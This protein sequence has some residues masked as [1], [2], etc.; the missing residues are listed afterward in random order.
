MQKI[1]QKKIRS[2]RVQQIFE[3]KAAHNSLSTVSVIYGVV[4]LRAKHSGAVYCYRSCLWRK[5]RRA[6][7][8]AGGR[9][10][11]RAVSEPY[12]SQRARS[13]VFASL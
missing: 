5:D 11:G 13:A 1:T 6:L 7:F 10:G 9:A 12:Y 3:A 8:V 2:T 4:T